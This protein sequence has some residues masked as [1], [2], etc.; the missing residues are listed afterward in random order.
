MFPSVTSFLD[1]VEKDTEATRGPEVVEGGSESN[2]DVDA[3]FPLL[4]ARCKLL[5][6]VS[7]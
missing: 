1:G 4:E 6:V 2:T 5:Y 7:L 3:D